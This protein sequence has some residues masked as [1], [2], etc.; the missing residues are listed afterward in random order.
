MKYKYLLFL[1]LAFSSLY[2]QKTLE[3]VPSKVFNDTRVVSVVLPTLYE[4]NEKKNY[5][6]LI[7]LDGE[8]LV[9]PFQGMLSY[10]SYWDDLPQAIIVGVNHEGAEGREYDTQTYKS[11]GLPEGQGDQFYQFIAN[12][13]IPYMEDNYRVAPFH[14]VAGHNLTGGFLNFFLYRDKPVFNAYISFSPIMPLE[15]ENRV[16]SAL[17]DVNKKT[18]YYMATASGD[19]KKIKEKINALDDN[20]KAIENPNLKYKFE[21][22]EGASHYSLVALGIPNALYFIFS[23]YQPISSKEYEEKIVTLESGYVDYLKDKYDIIRNDL[24]VNEPIRLN[25]FKAI[26]AAIIKNAAYDELEDLADVA[27][28]EYPKMIIGVYYQGLHHELKGETRKAIRSYLKGYNYESI[29][30]YTKDLIIEKAE[31]LKNLVE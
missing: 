9:D 21:E 11:T 4:E 20:I 5:P 25:D 15:M 18:Y 8:Y 29:G 31:V 28:K 24:G 16:A 30:D 22:F 19:V 10:T 13:L 12:E 14:V 7:L 17:T 27:K 1:L 26:E 3:D 6:L 23:K 2:P